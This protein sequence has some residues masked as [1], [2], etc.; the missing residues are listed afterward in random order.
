VKKL[1]LMRILITLSLTLILAFGS[2]A[3]DKSKI[4]PTPDPNA[5]FKV[6]IPKDLE[7]AFVELSKM[8]SPALLNEIRL[9]SER[10]MIEYHHG[11]G[12][13]LRNN[14]GLWAGL[15]LAQYFRQL[16]I[17]HPDDM[18][19]IIL[20]SFWRHL[21]SQPIKLEE[22]VEAYKEYWR[23]GAEKEAAI[24]HVSETAMSSPL[25]ASSGETIRLSAY[26]GEV[27]LL[28]WLDT[29]CG[30]TDRGC[31]MVSSLVKLKIEYSSQGVEVIGLV[32]TY[33]SSNFRKASNLLK[34]FVADRR[35][36]FPVV[37]HDDKFSYDVSSYDEFGYM[38][39][40]QIFVISRDGYVL[41][42][43]RGFNPQKDPAVLR[44]TIEQALK[45]S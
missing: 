2:L 44:E 18:S 21:H 23:K 35:I 37:W 24:T 27:I 17:N 43:V 22:Q 9:K 4:T 11:F 25:K 40:P 10:D 1:K 13:W 30:F 38:S 6:Y 8:L 7:D 26:K 34:R 33:P 36:N 16:G 45:Q 20:T 12:K 31:R 29:S 39:F 32:G 5:P 14:W 3:Q 28:A 41:K 15:R 42:R 19:G